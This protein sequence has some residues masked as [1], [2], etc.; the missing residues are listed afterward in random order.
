MSKTGLGMVES[1]RHFFA[2]RTAGRPKAVAGTF[3]NVPATAF[4]LP[5]A[6]S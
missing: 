1:A 4:G 2:V 6:K 3:M 5:A